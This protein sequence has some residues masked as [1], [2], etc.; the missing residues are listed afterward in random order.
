MK[1]VL[2]SGAGIA[3]LALAHRLSHHGYAPTVVERAPAVRA[4]GQAIDVR[5]VALD[6]LERMN[7]LDQAR[8]AR[9]RMRGMSMLDGEGNELWRSTEMTFSSGRL[10]SE[11]IELLRE[12]LTQLLYR[13]MP[14]GVEYLFGDSISALQEEPHGV[15]VGF[16]G[17]GSRMFDL[18]VGADGL[19]SKVRHL[20]F[21]AKSHFVRHL[22]SYVA[23]FT[24][25]NFLD[26][27]D[28]Q[29]WLQDGSGSAT[30]CLYPAREN[31]ELRAT[32]GFSSEPLTYDHRDPEQ[33]KA[34]LADR[35]SQVRWETP[36]LLKAMWAAPD[37]YFD[38]MAQVRMERWSQGR[39][40][41]LGDAGYCPSPLS[42]Q[43]SSLALAGAYVLAEE[44]SG[45]AGD[46]R[47]A[48]A[49]YEERLR[50]FVELN[51]ALATENPGQG[52]DEESVERAK[53]AISL[54]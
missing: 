45:A 21:G 20:A 19:R 3:G 43:G 48:F 50:P 15:R 5:G 39:V 14:E 22:G 26:L 10:D 54:D 32:V 18:V 51:Q 47:C 8:R 38:A 35:L 44:L 46:H 53:N 27:D 31:T 42:G 17:G 25:E 9:T 6:V 1:S 33:H 40:V 24:T 37:F 52:A 2:I 11:D 12:D 16:E 41:L 29:V 7:L 13:N 30:Y 4:G 28:W 34:L 36:R 49:R 23:V